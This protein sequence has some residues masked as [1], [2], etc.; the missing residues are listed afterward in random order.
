M[1]S[2]LQKAPQFPRTIKGCWE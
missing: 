1:A 2:D